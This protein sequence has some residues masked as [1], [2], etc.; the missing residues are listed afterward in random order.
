[1]GINTPKGK[2]P[3]EQG[4][5]KNKVK[6]QYLNIS[7][8]DLKKKAQLGE[9]R[10]FYTNDLKNWERYNI[11]SEEQKQ[12]II[13]LE[14]E[15]T[16]TQELGLNIT[17]RDINLE[18]DSEQIP[19]KG[20]LKQLMHQLQNTLREQKQIQETKDSEIEK[21]KKLLSEAQDYGN[22]IIDSS[23]QILDEN[24]IIS[25]NEIIPEE[26]EDDKVVAPLKVTAPV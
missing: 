6:P 22:N 8:E 17:E 7:E 2:A 25:E 16:E 5:N 21:L 19:G 3:S 20:N 1:M 10:W 13:D 15:I 12:K 23:T 14:N 9:Y 26:P 11:L 24:E 4:N 18:E